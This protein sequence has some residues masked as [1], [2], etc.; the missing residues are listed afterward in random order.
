MGSPYQLRDIYA[1]YHQ[2]WHGCVYMHIMHIEIH[3]KKENP[4]ES[5]AYM[6]KTAARFY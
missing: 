2:F 1:A 4:P 5:M 3:T 6:G